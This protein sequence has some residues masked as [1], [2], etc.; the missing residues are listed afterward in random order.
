M[1]VRAQTISKRRGR[2][3][4]PAKQS[5]IVAWRPASGVWQSGVAWL[6]RRKVDYRRPRCRISADISVN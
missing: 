1:Y 3:T 2:A 4:D 5:P 6:N